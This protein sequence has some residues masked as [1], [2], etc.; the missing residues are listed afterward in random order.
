MN[1][2]DTLR[3]P[4]PQSKGC[5]TVHDAKGNAMDVRGVLP[6]GLYTVKIATGTVYETERYLVEPVEG[7]FEVVQGE[8]WP[9]SVVVTDG[10]NHL[11]DATVI[12]GSSPS[13][14]NAAGGML[15]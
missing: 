7:V 8:L 10:V 9:V 11:Q 3:L 15:P 13:Q 5:F 12:V 4:N 2:G 6:I 14:T 1:E